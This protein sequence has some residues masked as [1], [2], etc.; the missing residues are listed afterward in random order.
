ME[1][2]GLPMSGGSRATVGVPGEVIMQSHVMN[3]KS[4]VNPND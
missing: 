4:V 3:N 1:K 2:T